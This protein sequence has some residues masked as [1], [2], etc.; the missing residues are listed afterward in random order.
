MTD[1]TNVQIAFTPALD[2]AL[3][4]FFAGVGFGFNP[5]QMRRSIR[6][7]ALRLNAKSD[8]EL[9]RLGISRADIPAYVLRH[10]LP[11]HAPVLRRRA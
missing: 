10:R 7:D 11:A 3:D 4:Q 2:L 5:A 1:A 8:A 9:S 6:R